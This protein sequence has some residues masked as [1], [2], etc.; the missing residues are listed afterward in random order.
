V[1][2][3]VCPTTAPLPQWARS[4]IPTLFGK[5]I[6]RDGKPFVPEAM[7]RNNPLVMKGL[8]LMRQMMVLAHQHRLDLFDR[9]FIR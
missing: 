8:V 5:F 6:R 4:T 1:Y 3:F 2:D 7:D 9:R